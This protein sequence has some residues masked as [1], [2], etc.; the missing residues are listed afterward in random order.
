MLLSNNNLNEK[1][2]PPNARNAAH[3]CANDLS[4]RMQFFNDCHRLRRQIPKT[5]G[6]YH[7]K[8]PGQ[9]NLYRSQAM[10]RHRLPHSHENHNPLL[11]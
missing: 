5:K 3:F 10:R 11:R 6:Q 4:R 7:D 1:M 2:M 9:E 8:L